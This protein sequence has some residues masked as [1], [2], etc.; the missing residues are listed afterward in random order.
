[1][2]E[3]ISRLNNTRSKFVGVR[4]T[5]KYRLICVSSSDFQMG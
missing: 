2:A 5:R 3:M 4:E 1:V